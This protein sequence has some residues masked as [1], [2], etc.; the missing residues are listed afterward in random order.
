M[1]GTILNYWRWN[2]FGATTLIVS[3]LVL[4]QTK[5]N[6]LSWDRA[7]NSPTIFLE[8]DLPLHFTFCMLQHFTSHRL[9][10]CLLFFLYLNSGLSVACSTCWQC[11]FFIT[12]TIREIARNLVT[13]VKKLYSKCSKQTFNIIANFHHHKSAYW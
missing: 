12:K 2:P 1:R 11:Y 10:M 5:E 13:A 7:T 9:Q 3:R 6:G 8:S 4:Q